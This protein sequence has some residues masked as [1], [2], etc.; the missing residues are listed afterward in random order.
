MAYAEDVS[1]LAR[2][3][4]YFR[5]VLNTTEKTQLVLMTLKAGEEIGEEVHEENDQT[6]VIV[7]GEGETV[8]EG[9]AKPVKSG[10]VVVVPAGTRHN[11]VNT[12]SGPMRLF[13]VYAPADHAPDTVHRTK[14][15]AEADEHDEP[16]GE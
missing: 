3:N 13:T 12:G 7:E 9:A 11:V 16:P 15:E 8:L 6:L 4:D 2:R 10:F 5:K 1:T 14:A